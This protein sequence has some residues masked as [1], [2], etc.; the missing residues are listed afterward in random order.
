MVEFSR[1]I[2]IVL[3]K[4][5]KIIEAHSSEADFSFKVEDDCEF[6]PVL[7][8][9][10]SY[11]LVEA[12]FPKYYDEDNHKYIISCDVVSPIIKNHLF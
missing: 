2:L 10:H 4:S 8:W 11:T 12:V 6:N 1:P 3:E 9:F 5:I 7:K